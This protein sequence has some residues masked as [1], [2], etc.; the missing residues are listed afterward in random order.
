MK[1]EHPKCVLLCIDSAA[2][3]GAAILIPEEIFPNHPRAAVRKGLAYHASVS[4]AVERT[5]TV[6]IAKG[7]ARDLGLP[8][9][10]VGEEWDAGG[11]WTHKTMM[12]IGASW[13]RWLEALELA[14]VPDENIFRMSVNEWRKTIFGAKRHKRA[15]WKM[16]AM[17]WCRTRYGILM[18]DDEAEAVCMGCAAL[19]SAKLAKLA[20][21]KRKARARKAKP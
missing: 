5:N 6:H 20:K 4:N 12:G 3:S 16:K 21:P 11:K 10:V 13:G 1:R 19:G 18:T 2:T 9:F 14:G 17:R 8:L 15:T 7:F